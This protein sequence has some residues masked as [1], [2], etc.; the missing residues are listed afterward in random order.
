MTFEGHFGINMGTISN[1]LETNP[2]LL[3][4]HDVTKMWNSSNWEQLQSTV[5]RQWL[6][7]KKSHYCYCTQI[8]LWFD[9]VINQTSNRLCYHAAVTTKGAL[10][11]KCN[12]FCL[13]VKHASLCMLYS[14][15]SAQ[16]RNAPLFQSPG[17]SNLITDVKQCPKVYQFTHKSLNTGSENLNP[18]HLQVICFC[19]CHEL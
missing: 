7:E 2:L 15:K 6:C 13:T 17:L 3:F 12:V 5:N 8:S 4:I 14:S 16:L 18:H 1:A 11:W 10:L 9:Q 19:R